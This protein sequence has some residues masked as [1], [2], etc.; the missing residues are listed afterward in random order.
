MVT[1]TLGAILSHAGYKVGTYTSPH[2][3]DFS[4]RIQINSTSITSHSIID[5]TKRLKP[6]IE[7]WRPSFFE[8]TVAMAFLY[9][10]EQQVDIACCRNRLGG[11]LGFYKYFISYTKCYYH[12]KR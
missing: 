10:A 4:E 11:N 7:K 1:H 8:I 9:F 12:Y 2:I 3:C 6:L 5:Y